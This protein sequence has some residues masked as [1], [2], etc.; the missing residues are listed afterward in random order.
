MTHIHTYKFTL[1]LCACFIMNVDGHDGKQRQQCHEISNPEQVVLPQRLSLSI[2]CFFFIF[3][4][5]K[6]YAERYKFN[7][8]MRIDNER[9]NQQFTNLRG[10]PEP[11]NCMPSR[12]PDETTMDAYG[13]KDAKGNE[14]KTNSDKC[15]G[16]NR[17]TM[18]NCIGLENRRT[19][20][21]KN[22]FKKNYKKQLQT[23]KRH[24]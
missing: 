16:Q 22:N 10:N 4:N 7:C 15:T 23:R 20:R 11:L 5:G 19:T 14:E 9:M 3:F 2:L 17:K 12:Q 1:C 13:I 18:R 24:K 21:K 6:G 8:V